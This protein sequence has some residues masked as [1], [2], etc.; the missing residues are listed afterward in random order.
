MKSLLLC[1][2]MFIAMFI[3]LK[4]NILGLLD[5]SVISY[6]LFGCLLLVI[7]LAVLLVGKPKLSD[8]AQAFKISQKKGD[9]DDK[10]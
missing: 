3:F 7:G 4:S 5:N 9:Y 2:V 1:I 8:I 6:V 10:K